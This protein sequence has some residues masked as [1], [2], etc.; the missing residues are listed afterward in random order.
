MKGNVRIIG[1]R[2][3]GRRLK[4]IDS[5]GLRPSG[6]RTRE[7][8]FN[9]LAGIVPG[10][11]CLDLF[12]GTGAL[13][14]EAASR[15]AGEV[16][17]VE[18]DARL[19]GAL[20]EIREEWSDAGAVTVVRDDALRWLGQPHAPFDLIFLDPPFDAGLET[21]AMALIAEQGLLA[22]GGR[23]YLETESRTSAPEG[24]VV[25]KEKRVGD[26]VIRLLGV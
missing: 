17:L 19:A 1:G 5:P 18:R 25:L 7:T 23:I 11:R 22:D 10:A 26:V 15:G 14:L 6:D 16:V 4:V 20:R 8:L 21:P 12:A 3:R 13:G 9:W 24:W 2:W